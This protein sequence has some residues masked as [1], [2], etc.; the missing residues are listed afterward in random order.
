MTASQEEGGKRDASWR[1]YLEDLFPKHSFRSAIPDPNFGA[2]SNLKE[3][4]SDGAPTNRKNI[5]AGKLYGSA[6]SPL[7]PQA[8]ESLPDYLERLERLLIR[9]LQQVDVVPSAPADSTNANQFV[10]AILK[11]GQSSDKKYWSPLNVLAGLG[12][13]HVM[14]LRQSMSES[15]VEM[16]YAVRAGMQISEIIHRLISTHAV[17]IAYRQKSTQAAENE[18]KEDRFIRGWLVSEKLSPD[19]VR[20]GGDHRADLREAFKR[21]FP[22]GLKDMFGD[23]VKRVTK[24][25]I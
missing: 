23:S 22:S 25:W 19:D 3:L 1:L 6:R 10:E 16:E 20:V 12:L 7:W 8:Y 15:S 4:L 13:A 9:L 5:A 14:D 21:E 18:T 24:R 11:G 2:N 17:M